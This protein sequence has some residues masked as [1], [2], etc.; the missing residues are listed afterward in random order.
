M[1]VERLLLPGVGI[2]NAV[3]GRVGICKGVRD[4]FWTRCLIGGHVG[5]ILTSCETGSV[6][7]HQVSS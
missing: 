1:V 7:E 2:V 5:L 6:E 4:A 3:G